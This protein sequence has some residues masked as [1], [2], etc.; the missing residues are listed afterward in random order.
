M[1]R[2]IRFYISPCF[3]IR[4][5]LQRDIKY[6]V[7]KFK[8]EGRVLDFGCG[9]KP[10]EHLFF[11]SEYIGIDFENYSKNK[12][13]SDKK[14]DYFFDEK[15]SKEM[16]LPF[17]NGSFDNTVSFQVLEHHRKPEVMIREMARV[18]KKEGLI[19]LTCPFVYALHEEPNDFQRLTEYKLR[20]LFE[21]N[22]CQIIRIKKQGGFFSAVSMLANE[23]L[24]YF[25]AKNRI[26]YLLA[27]VIYP[28]FLLLQYTSILVDVFFRSEKV[29]INY[30]VLAKKL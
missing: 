3:L 23:Q 20:E 13:I 2:K 14:P 10:Y 21:K 16:T 11:N 27:C 26:N 25:A 7:K 28:L 8:F 9:Q 15:Y 22:N 12:E 17:E 30:I 29:F 6:F 4:Y 18:V 24:N 1:L 5:Y 19:L